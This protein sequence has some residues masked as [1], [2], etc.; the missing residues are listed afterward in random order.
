MTSPTLSLLMAL[1][2]LGAPLGAQDPHRPPSPSEFAGENDAQKE[3]R[4]L[5]AKVER[6]LRRID[7]Y[8]SDAAAGDVPL[9]LPEESGLADLLRDTQQRS[10]RAI[11]DIDRI[12]EIA[13]QSQQSSGPGE[14]GQEPPPPSG[15]SPLDQPRSDRPQEQENTPEL[16]GEEQEG[17]QPRD[18][19][20]RPDSPEGSDDT[21]ENNENQ[22]PPES[23][24]GPGQ[25]DTSDGARWG[26][27]PSRV[28]EI[29]RSQ[30][31]GDLPVQYRDWIDSYYRRLNQRR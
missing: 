7:L 17:D 23:P 19:N 25:T 13:S 4:E 18:E 2:S 26:E 22:N 16:P 8:L 21:P 24:A 20:G 1:A 28:R 15:E 30:G 27:L 5:F 3:M 14:S 11:R 31:G 9:D 6:T 10:Q 12:M 29:F